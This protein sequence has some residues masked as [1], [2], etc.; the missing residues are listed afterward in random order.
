MPMLPHS[1]LRRTGVMRGTQ[2]ARTRGISSA[3]DPERAAKRAAERASSSGLDEARSV[4]G[5]HDKLAAKLQAGGVDVSARELDR[6]AYRDARYRGALA[7]HRYHDELFGRA[8]LCPACRAEIA[9][10]HAPPG[11][12]CRGIEHRID[13][14]STLSHSHRIDPDSIQ[15]HNLTLEPG[16]SLCI[17]CS[18]N[19]SV[20]H[21]GSKDTLSLG[22][23]GEKLSLVGSAQIPEHPCLT[24][25]EAYMDARY[26]KGDKVCPV[27]H[28]W[29]PRKRTGAAAT[30]AGDE[31]EKDRIRVW[32]QP[33]RWRKA[34]KGE[35]WRKQGLHVKNGRAT[36]KQR[37]P[38]EI[39]PHAETDPQ[40]QYEL[41][42][43]LEAE[44]DKATRPDADREADWQQAAGWFRTAAFQGHAQARYR[45][46]L[47]Y[48][49]AKGVRKDLRQ[50]VSLLR[51]AAKEEAEAAFQLGWCYYKGIGEGVDEDMALGWWRVALGMGHLTA[52]DAISQAGESSG[53]R[54]ERGKTA[55]LQYAA[56]R[57][58]TQAQYDVACRLFQGYTVIKDEK[59]AARLYQLAAS[60][61]NVDAMC[62]IGLCCYYGRGVTTDQRA[63]VRWLG[64]A[65]QLGHGI[66]QSALA[67][68]HDDGTAVPRDPDRARVL[69]TEAARWQEMRVSAF[70]RH[71]AQGRGGL[72]RV[73]ASSLLSYI[74]YVRRHVEELRRCYAACIL[75]RHMLSGSLTRSFRAG[76]YAPVLTTLESPAGDSLLVTTVT[77]HR[78]RG[79]VSRC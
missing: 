24:P 11:K 5:G 35:M 9:P 76:L 36:E 66:A 71:A 27:C 62:A 38:Q 30:G 56:A 45:L 57:G 10:E 41:G 59:E 51:K 12:G 6:E 21:G 54:A 50:G 52:L 44:G 61:G 64:A 13:L 22:G 67:Y 7:A 74:T 77:G 75:A 1:Q 70:Y 37:A 79:L 68:M 25:E 19:S 14:D 15:H 48:L 2:A 34:A 17:G 31:D 69:R 42:C 39:V 26:T 43:K 65:A 23:H 18:G 32:G 55:S 49:H 8:P 40:R 60:Q 4:P 47:C 72:I 58:D 29:L 33:E 78:S 53:S 3:W 73:P 16:L 46:G 20:A 28:G 63:A